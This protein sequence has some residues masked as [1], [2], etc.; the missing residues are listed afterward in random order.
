MIRKIVCR[1]CWFFE[2]IADYIFGDRASELYPS[3]WFEPKGEQPILVTI[4]S[5]WA[6]VAKDWAVFGE[7]EEDALRKFRD[8]EIRHMKIA[9]RRWRR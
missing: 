1:I 9:R 5:G 4:K 6:A 3:R 8:A 2:D 7:T